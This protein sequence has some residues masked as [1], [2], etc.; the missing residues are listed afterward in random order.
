MV[1][2]KKQINKKKKGFTLIELLAVIVILGLLMAI[3]IPSVTKYIIQS[4]KKTVTSTIGNYIGALTNEVNDMEY[5][6][7]EPNTVYAVPIECIELERGGASPFGSWYQGDGWAYAL[8]QYDN[9]VSSYKYGFTFKDSAGYGIYPTT[10]EKLNSD[11]EQVQTGLSLNQPKD[12]KIVEIT[13]EKNWLGFKIDSETN[14]VVLEAT[15]NSTEVDGINKCM[16]CQKGSN[17]EEVEQDKNKKEGFLLTS[18]IMDHNQVVSTP[19][20]LKQTSGATGEKGLYSTNKTTNGKVSYYFRGNVDNNNVKFAGLDWKIIRINEDD[21]IRLILDDY[22]DSYQYS[23]KIDNYKYMYYSESDAARLTVNDWYKTNIIDKNFDSYVADGIFCE[24]AK[25]KL[26]DTTIGENASMEVYTNYTSDLDCDLDGNNKGL[27][28]GKVGLITIDEYIHAGENIYQMDGSSYIAASS[29]WT[30]SPAG[31]AVNAVG[32]WFSTVW[33]D[34]GFVLDSV[35]TNGYMS[36]RPVINLKPDT[37]VIGN[38][39]S[40]TPYEVQ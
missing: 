25:V 11:G 1:R 36:L 35:N 33:Y 14:L 18:L 4:K 2:K 23:T 16:L 3:A 12:G 20:N 13:D 19:A 32:D 28:P 37:L 38:G 22:I 6:F 5:K 9:E 8:V 17:Y 7:T 10:I 21:T 15:E 29:V 40:G 39:T 30:M 26:K 31:F 24:E 34:V 27:V